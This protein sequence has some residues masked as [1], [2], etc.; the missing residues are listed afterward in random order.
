MRQEMIAK[1]NIEALV[2]VCAD[3]NNVWLI[4]SHFHKKLAFYLVCY[5]VVVLKLLSFNII[6]LTVSKPKLSAATECKIEDEGCTV[7]QKVER[8]N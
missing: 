5:R 4:L 3:R 7:K 1:T 8:M 6:N 2:H